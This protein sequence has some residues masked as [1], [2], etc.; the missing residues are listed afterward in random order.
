ML[1]Y[2]ELSSTEEAFIQSVFDNQGLSGRGYYRIL[3][4]ARTIAD[5]DDS[6]RIRMKHLTEAVAYRIPDLSVGG[7]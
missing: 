2:C 7:V 3:K 6:E 4:L 1:K 5:M